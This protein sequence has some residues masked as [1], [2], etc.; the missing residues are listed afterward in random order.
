[1]ACVPTQ[2]VGTRKIEDSDD[3]KMFVA[4]ALR[5]LSSGRLRETLIL[6]GFLAR[7]H[8]LVGS[9]RVSVALRQSAPGQATV[10]AATL[11]RSWSP[12]RIICPPTIC[13]M[14]SGNMSN[15][16]AQLRAQFAQLRVQFSGACACGDRRA[17][18]LDHSDRSGARPLLALADLIFHI[19]AF[20]EIL[21]RHTLHFR[22]V[23]EQLPLIPFDEPET[24]IRHHFFDRTLWHGCPPQI[25]T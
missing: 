10:P 3:R 8:I 14:S 4:V 25:Q 5:P 16:L 12:D 7:L 13:R 22:V 20:V 24:S 15:L 2:S 11:M 21:E 23:E 1:M 9:R 17:A 6:L 19:L 18:Q